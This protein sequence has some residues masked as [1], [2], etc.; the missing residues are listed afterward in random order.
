MM[1]RL[2]FVF[3]C[4]LPV[5][6]CL[7]PAFLQAAPR[8]APPAGLR[9]PALTSHAL[10]GAKIVVSPD[11][12]ID[13][14]TIV[15]RDGVIVAVGDKVMPPAD[16]QIHDGAGKTIYA[17]F[18]DAYSELS[19]DA[20]RAVANDK[21]GAGYWNA[22]IL[23]QVRASAIY[24]S[25][26]EANRKYR[27]QGITARL[28][29]PSAG[30][31]KGT[32]ALVTTADESGREAILKEQVAL[33]AKLT[34]TRGAGGGYPNSPMGAYT[35]VRQAFYDAGW[36]GQAW[37]AYQ[38][39]HEL[40]RPERS[41]ALAVL[42]GYLGG[43]QP[44]V[45]DAADELYLLRA[46]RIG[47]EFGL[48]VIVRGSGE[49]YRRIA[50]IVATHRAVIVP[51]D[52]PKAPNVATPESAANVTLARLMQWDIA[53]EN[54]ARLVDAGVKIAF[55]TRGLKDPAALLGAVRKAVERGLKPDAALRA[56]TITP[57]ELFGAADRLGTLEVGKAANLVVADGD[58][59]AGKTK[60]L[61]T[62]IDGDRYEVD[63]PPLADV[64]G[65]WSVEI[66]KPD[67]TKETLALEIKGQ[68]AKLSGKIKRGDKSTALV[69]PALTE[70]HFTAS[71]KGEPLGFEGMLQLTATVS[72]APAAADKAAPALSWLGQVVWAS[73]ERT[74]ST[75]QRD[76]AAKP[77]D[78]DDNADD[79]KKP[80]DGDTPKT[81]AGAEA[82]PDAA[83]EKGA[84]AKTD[85]GEKKPDAEAK[86]DEKP[87]KPVRSLAEVNYP[88]GEF[89]RKTAPDQP[90]IVIFRNATVWT[91]GPQGRL[92]NA[93]V[94]VEQGKIKAVGVGLAA[95]DQAIVVNATGKH[96]SPGIIDCHSHV[97][98]DGGVNESGQTITAEV[99][100]GDFVDPNDINIYRQLGGG[101]T[102]S[103]ILHGSANT[104]GGQNQV[105]KFRWGAGPEE[106]KF[107]AAPQGI[108]FALGENVKQSNW[109]ERANNRYPQSRMGVEQLV[110]D[111]FRAAQ[112]YRR[113]QDEWKRTKTGLPPR[114]DLELEALAEVLEGKRLI[115]C[116][117]Y[118]QDEILA[119]LRT[120]E[121]FQV[122]IATLQH[123]LEGYK[124][125]DVMA[126]QGVGGSSF[127]DWWA[128]KFEV[129]DAIPY[130]GALMHNAGVVV[131]FNSDDAELAR[132][133]NLEAAKAV[134]Y[135]GVP[136]EE[137]LKFVT[138]NPARQLRIDGHVGSL[139]PGK[140]ADLV[141]WSASPLSTYS[142][143]EQTWVDG[144]RYFDLDEDRQARRDAATLR[145]ALVQRVLNSGEP[146][147][148]P[149]EEK[150]RE[151]DLWPRE[152]LFCHHGEDD[153]GH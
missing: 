72:R 33:H 80:D 91:S 54:P 19:A 149:D 100:V 49:E 134:K 95:P 12:T 142:R 31:V 127:S 44:V 35:L 152:D 93:D 36:Y 5:A 64:R 76:A 32:S 109:G 138:L 74:T 50:E 135:G 136:P 105:L 112:Q 81:P 40:P 126:K 60:V 61:E 145:A 133:L 140:D 131:S 38:A 101:V 65:T 11:R 144:R 37:D 15:W 121:S 79:K 151:S 87:K 59:F 132:R 139:E 130:N 103:N 114:T 51:L 82:K 122:K 143:C 7:L 3:L 22:N 118:R 102:S 47:K 42:R 8:L 67:G 2:R 26:A 39:N 107:A 18:I 125:A 106:M 123:I 120:C 89:G 115:H 129:F 55:T 116:H 4:A 104:I 78:S 99:R 27:S 71:F 124:L 69:N 146:T 9:E 58:L 56:L 53:P 62:W 66:A 117:S 90:A 119:L 46:D 70:W 34:V 77:S 17:G 150:K 111:A 29:A 25:D 94:L 48:D 43:K 23:P 110:R 30:I 128:Y 16:A 41:D 85:S 108:K 84:D 75:A 45:I 24:S 92:E 52:F 97:A 1:Y 96:I 63:A 98:T 147:A 86:K 148:T 73:G 88:L 13:N 113:S 21:A 57:A 137:A 68:P 141:V 153:H 10:V 28:V 6:A 83:A 20:S 14:G